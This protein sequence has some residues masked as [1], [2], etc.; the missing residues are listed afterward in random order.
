[1]KQH[2]NAA[3]FT[4][5]V[6]RLHALVHRMVVLVDGPEFETAELHRLKRAVHFVQVVRLVRVDASEADE[7]FRMQRHVTRHQIVGH[8]HAHV[9]GSHTEDDHLVHRGH[10]LP[11]VGFVHV[12]LRGLTAR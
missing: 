6:Y 7:L 9:L 10:G 4:V 5:G 11:V 1:M 12:H 3:L 2:R 8:Q